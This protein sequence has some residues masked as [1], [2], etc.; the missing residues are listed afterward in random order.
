MRFSTSA[1]VLGALAAGQ[2]AAATMYHGKQHNHAARHSDLMK[3]HN[4]RREKW[5]RDT[6]ILTATDS[7]TLTSLGFSA[8]GLNPT[9]SGNTPWIG[10]D[11]QWTNEFINQSGEDLILV[12][13]GPSGSWVNAIQPQLTV[14]IPANGSKTV[15]FP[16]GWSGAWAPVYGDSSLKNGQ[17]YDTWGEGTFSAPYSVVDVSREVNMKG[18]S[19][20]IVTPQCTTDMDTC[21]FKCS[22]DVDQCLTGYE[23]VN[24]AT[25]SQAGAN[26][27]FHN[28][29]ASGGC[30]GMGESAAL[31]TYFG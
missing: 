26:F 9:S 17:V 10:A 15:S 25:G 4:E 27:G 19:M 31:K 24:C 11:G 13:W 16:N 20:S 14:S 30:G 8:L 29:A 22:D 2:A 1:L 7:N 6:S 28:G 5:T 18:R 12:L 23:L 21:V 3:A